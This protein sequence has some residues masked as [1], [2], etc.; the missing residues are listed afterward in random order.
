M[1]SRRLVICGIKHDPDFSPVDQLDVQR[2]TV[3][4]SS[5]SPKLTDKRQSER[6]KAAARELGAD[7]SNDAFDRV[8]G[9]MARQKSDTDE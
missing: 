7:E 3:C 6:F 9:E 5:A 1:R 8:L 2:K 4:V